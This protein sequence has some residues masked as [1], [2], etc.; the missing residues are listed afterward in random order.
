MSMVRCARFKLVAYLGFGKLSREVSV[1]GLL[2][3]YRDRTAVVAI[4]GLGYVG[5]PL[6][7]ASVEAGFEVIGLDIDPEKIAALKSGRRYIRHL[8][9]DVLTNAISQ[10]RFHPT[11]EFSKFDSCR[12]HFDLRTH[13]TD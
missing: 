9:T 4:I 8:P 11:T 2:A 1:E 7:K 6:A 12:C 10:D 5:L 3:R 13:P